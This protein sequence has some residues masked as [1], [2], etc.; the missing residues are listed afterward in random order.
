MAGVQWVCL[1]RVKDMYVTLRSL[2]CV[3]AH[4]QLCPT[5]H[6]PWTAAC[7]PPPS[8]E[9][10][11]QE[12]QSGLPWPPPG[13]LPD[14]G[15]KPVSLASPALAVGLFITREARIIIKHAYN[16]FSRETFTRY[17]QEM[18][19]FPALLCGW[20]CSVLTRLLL[21]DEISGSPSA[22]CSLSEDESQCPLHTGVQSPFQS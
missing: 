14:P 3:C 6:S 22:S 7:Q 2:F 4:T 15:V 20:L 10:S 8:I 1:Q 13:D 18:F 5:L 11:K 12:Y 16:P 9:F 19:S 17:N 21:P